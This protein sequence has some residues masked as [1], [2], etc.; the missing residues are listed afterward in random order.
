MRGLMAL[1]DNPACQRGRALRINE[2][3][4]AVYKTAWSA[5]PSAGFRTCGIVA[6][7]PGLLRLAIS[8]VAWS[9]NGARLCELQQLRKRGRLA[10]L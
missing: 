2:E 8:R 7:I 4:H 10:S 1:S 6:S 3:V 5:W 9:C